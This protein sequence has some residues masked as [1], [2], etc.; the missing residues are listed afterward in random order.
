[1]GEHV[2]ELSIQFDG[3]QLSLRVRPASGEE[4][5]SQVVPLAGPRA[6]VA[7]SSSSSAQAA[8]LAW[9]HAWFQSFLNAD[10]IEKLSALDISPVEHL[11]SNLHARQPVWTPRRRVARAFRAGVLAGLRLRGSDLPRALWA[12]KDCYRNEWYIVLRAVPGRE[13]GWTK[14]ADLYL[15]ATEESG[16][17]HPDSISHGFATETEVRAYLAGARV[18]WPQLY[19][20][21]RR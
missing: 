4:D 9:S 7:A 12:P 16:E 6:E 2:D 19:R 10:S 11:V 5:H 1:M 17:V 15:D 8:P 18:Q 21:R 3:L 20:P 13:P 14:D